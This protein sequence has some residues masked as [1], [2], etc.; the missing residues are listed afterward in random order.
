MSYSTDFDELLGDTV[1]VSALS[2]F[3]TDGYMVATYAAG[4]TY[5]GR[6]V[7]KTE[8]VRTFEGTE[9]L[10]RS[11]VWVAST[12]TFAPSSKVTVAGSTVG[13]IMSIEAYPDEDGVHHL[14][15]FFG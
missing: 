15:V 4:S 7:R 13:P 8:L 11:Q 2:S 14:K 1:V 6:H 10:S 12:S 3:S 5:L 9:A